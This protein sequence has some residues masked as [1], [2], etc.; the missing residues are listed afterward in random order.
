MDE[1]LAKPIRP[2]ELDELLEHF[3]QTRGRAAA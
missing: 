2:E 1:Y 3:I